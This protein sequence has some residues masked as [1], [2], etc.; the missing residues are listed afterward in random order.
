MTHT[1]LRIFA[2]R[3]IMV[4]LLICLLTCRSSADIV[5]ATRVS[6]I[7]W[8][9]AGSWVFNPDLPRNHPDNR[10]NENYHVDLGNFDVIL[11]G[12]DVTISEF[13]IGQ[14]GELNIDL[15]P[16]LTLEAGGTINNSGRIKIGK[17][18]GANLVIKDGEDQ[19]GQCYAR[20]R[21]NQCCVDERGRYYR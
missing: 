4:L 16:G 11:G 1:T 19:C 10:P 14:D 6:G 17:G 3:S 5:T 21:R 15:F 20:N 13:A 2:V 12:L 7:N 18:A 9:D 8:G